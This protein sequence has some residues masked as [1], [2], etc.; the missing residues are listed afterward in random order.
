MTYI[1]K[2]PNAANQFVVTCDHDDDDRLLVEGGL[3]ITDEVWF[4]VRS[5]GFDD[6]EGPLI[7]LSM[8]ENKFDAFISELVDIQARRNGVKPQ[9][10]RC[11]GWEAD[12]AHP[13][14]DKNGIK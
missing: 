11:A 13:F 12:D 10:E 5:N 2:N 6:N 7:T 1:Y 3:D 14:Y 4:S 8:D 9:S